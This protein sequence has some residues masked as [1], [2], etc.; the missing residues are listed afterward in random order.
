[1]ESLTPGPPDDAARY[2]AL[3][4]V[5]NAIMSS[6]TRDALFRAIADALREVMSFDRT[7]IFLHD[8]GRDVLRLYLLD[9]EM[10]SS[11]FHLGLEMPASESHVGWVFRNRQPLLRE[12]LSAGRQWEMEERAY[13]DGVRSYVIVPLIA[14]GRA[15]GTLAVASAKAGRYQKSDADFLGEVGGQVALAVENMK[16][17]EAMSS[18]NAEL[19]AALNE[20]EA[21]RKRL[22]AENVYLQEEI[23]Q[24]HN[25]EEIVGRSAALAALLRKV[26]QVARTDSTVLVTGE[27]GTGK[28]LVARAI[29]RQSAR[30][31]R[32]L[33]VV[34][35]SAISA[36]LVESELFGHVRGA[37]T[38]ALERRTGRFE[39]ADRGT[40]FLDEIGELPLDTQV[41]LLRVLQE[42][43][44]EPVG[45]NR[46]VH[47][48]VRVIAATN[49]DLADAVKTGG[50]R[51]DLFYRLN[52][53]PLA[54][55]P[56]RERRDDIAL[57]ATYFLVGFARRFGKRIDGI[58][59]ATLDRLTAYGWPG[60][61]RELG[62]VIERAVVLSR[63]GMLE[64]DDDLLP[65]GTSAPARAASP[66]V[67]DARGSGLGALLEDTERRRILEA[68]EHAG[69]VIEGPR[70]A[71][72]LLR[73]HPNTLRSRMKR[74]R[75]QAPRSGKS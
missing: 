31:D 21:L 22:E 55:P 57:L 43:T 40:I 3:L 67:D 5:T 69:G 29:H 15:V 58:A 2:R 70:G 42:R 8:A 36:G 18:L 65:T 37:F 64:L 14:Q 50:F 6:L 60:N 12:D 26:E 32:P 4:H 75:I 19:T 72:I 52:V 38:G 11:Y 30:A 35:C 56:L 1:M 41:K 48:D 71:A 62:N 25:T 24:S 9:S 53:F 33:V 27:T 59:P 73:I 28:E 46:T 51:A 54:V 20:V 66:D 45:S 34:N 10:S 47:V 7:A 13:A 61:V 63:D 74:L 23:R 49:R 17:Y 68:L 44:F 39:L 16:A